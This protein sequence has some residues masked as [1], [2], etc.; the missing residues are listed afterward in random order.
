MHSTCFQFKSL[1][2][3]HI[4]NYTAVL[5]VHNALVHSIVSSNVSVLVLLNVGA[6][7]DTVGHNILLSV[8]NSQ[9][10]VLHS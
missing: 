4:I 7:F 6:V 10:F 8:L 2:T 3:V 5:S 9:H 1:P